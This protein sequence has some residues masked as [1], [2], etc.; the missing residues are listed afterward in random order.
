M[1]EGNVFVGDLQMATFCR[2]KLVFKLE[3][4]SESL[5]GLVEGLPTE[6]LIH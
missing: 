2:Y 5:G 3:L 4:A 1:G 6:F